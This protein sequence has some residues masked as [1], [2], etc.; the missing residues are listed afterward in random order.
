MNIPAEIPLEC[1]RAFLNTYIQ[2]GCRYSDDDM[3]N[4][5]WWFSYGWGKEPVV[6]M[7]I[8]KLEM[9]EN[10]LIELEVNCQEHWRSRRAHGA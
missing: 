6:A 10:R 1:V 2:R 4:A 7:S 8:D 5:L 3:L 9:L